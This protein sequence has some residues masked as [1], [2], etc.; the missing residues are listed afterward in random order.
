MEEAR[1]SK[2]WLRVA[3]AESLGDKQLRERLLR[4]ADE[5]VAML[6]TGMKKVKNN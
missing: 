2:Y 3:N 4:E 1:E 6:T 5:W